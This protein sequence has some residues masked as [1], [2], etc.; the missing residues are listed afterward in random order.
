MERRTY[1]IRDFPVMQLA[2]VLDDWYISMGFETQ[3]LNTQYKGILVQARK[4]GFLRSVVGMSTA[5]SVTINQLE[6]HMQIEVG[7]ANWADKAGAAAIGVVVFWP[8]LVSAGFGAYEQS[9][10]LKQSWDVI[11]RYIQTFS[12]KSNQNVS[13]PGF[14]SERPPV[15]PK[16]SQIPATCLLTEGESWGKLTVDSG[17][18]SG[19]TFDLNLP[20]I[21]IG[22]NPDCNII[23]SRDESISRNHA[24][25]YLKNGDAILSD[26]GSTHGT[27][28]NE[29]KISTYTLKDNSIIQIGKTVMRYNSKK[30][31]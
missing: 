4:E 17:P 13:P 5:I 12:R 15:L 18:Y 24:C 11:D 6:S 19:Q 29:N 16:E 3:I 9:K 14:A 25:I 23:L 10:M 8:T 27:F 22:R 1:P 31:F 21:S 7:G 2:E 26:Q 28:V 30:D 20:L